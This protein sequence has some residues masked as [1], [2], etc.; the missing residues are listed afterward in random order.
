VLAA[1]AP[2]MTMLAT[3]RSPSRSAFEATEASVAHAPCGEGL[4]TTHLCCVVT[5]SDAISERFASARTSSVTP[6]TSAAP[7]TLPS[8]TPGTMLR[9]SGTTTAGASESDTSRASPFATVIDRS[10]AR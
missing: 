10:A 8:T 4:P 3:P 1:A 7:A 5:V 9:L 6:P 2:A